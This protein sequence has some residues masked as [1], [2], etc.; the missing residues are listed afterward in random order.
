MLSSWAGTPAFLCDRH[1]TVVASNEAARALSPAFAEGM[2]L[3]RFTFLEA[4]LD[5]DHV[6]YD[7]AA[8]Q[9]AALLRE[10]LDQHHGDDLS[11]R[12]I[13]GDLS[14]MSA[15]FAAA[16]ADDSLSANSS[17]VVDFPDT[18]VG[19]VR[20]GYQVLRVP[21]N[22]EDCLLVWTAADDVSSRAFA[23]LLE[24]SASEGSD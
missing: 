12:E 24:G 10:S 1:F 9:V 21:E 8:N 2:N 23:R 22:E 6:M 17:G 4:E 14:V 19:N 7:S 11:F 15:D 18:A 13:V 16:W 20:M 3:A 5:R